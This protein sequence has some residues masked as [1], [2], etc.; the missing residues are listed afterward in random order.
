M[1]VVLNEQRK[2]K[3]NDD[4][5]IDLG[6][7]WQTIRRYL[8]RIIS[9]AIVLTLLVALIVMSI[10][11]SYVANTSLL[12]ESEQANVSSIEEVYGLDATKKEYFQTQYAI[13]K[14]RKI[15]EKV[16][17]KL[18]LVNSRLFDED[19]AIMI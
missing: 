10:T 14:S 16:A 12:I 7:Y 2:A 4:E 6:Q 5:V 19:V 8:S 17:T 1:S 15:A 13:L 11:P 18:N 3:L 9:L